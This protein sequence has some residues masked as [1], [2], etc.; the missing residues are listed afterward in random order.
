MQ[1]Q[2][3]R[4]SGISDAAQLNYTASPHVAELIAAMGRT[5]DVRFSPSNRRLAVAGYLK[6]RCT[7][8]DI[9]IDRAAARPGIVIRDA[10]TLCSPMLNEPHGFDFID[11]N[12]LV[13]ANRSGI[14]V[15]LPIPRGA[16]AGRTVDI[17]PTTEIRWVGPE[18]AIHS[19]GSVCVGRRGLLTVE[20]LVCNNYNNLISR[21]IIPAWRWPRK[22]WNS[23]LLMDGLEIPDGITLSPNGSRLAISN[24]SRHEVRIY[25]RRAHLS[26]RSKA[27]G[28][29]GGVAYPHGLRFS[30]D[31]TQLWV[32][33]AGAPSVAIFRD[34]TGNWEGAHEPD[35]VI[36]VLDE[37]TFLKGRANP[38]EGGPKGLDL[39][40]TG[41]I[42]V[43]TNELQPLAF[44]HAPTLVGGAEGRKSLA[45]ELTSASTQHDTSR[46]TID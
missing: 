30:P 21:H 27:H 44:F 17:A 40:A 16:S 33:D 37:A 34:P 7:L 36:T 11:E 10:M 23:V 20:L 4:L 41:D 14:V 22:I 29:L 15:V 31:G 28:I 26:P 43:I 25:D 12:T 3:A 8:L 24:H 45:S 46:S 42:V 13:V 6:D 2:R 39:D 5:E 18:Q 32:A 38:E 1:T 9:E 19:P 35:A